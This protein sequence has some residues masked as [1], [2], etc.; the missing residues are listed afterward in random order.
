MSGSARTSRNFGRRAIAAA[1]FIWLG[2]F[3]ALPFLIVLK[4]SFSVQTDGRPP[5]EPVFD[6]SQGIAALWQSAQRLSGESYLALI[7]DRLYVDAFV[8][9]IVIAGVATLLCLS[10]A[11][12]LA[13]AMARAPR[14][15]RPFLVILAIAPFWTS[16]L[17]RIYA[18]IAILKD[19]GLLNHALISMGL[20]AE[21]L[22][23]YATTGAVLI[24]TVYS[25]LPFMVLPLYNALEKQDPALVEAA[26]D[27]GATPRRAFLSI[28]LPLSKGGVVAGSLLVFI[29]A[30]GEFVIP[31]LLGPS[32]LLMI[33][34][35][36]WDE[37]SSSRNWPG[38]SA[39]AVIMLCVLVIPIVYYQ[40]AQLRQTQART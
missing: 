26:L 22:H 11:Y 39:V 20:I 21:P 36:L 13:L 14:R 15:M 27:L 25:Y 7:Q 31:D 24:G 12:P 33:G 10:I 19:E 16:F 35:T 34:R 23:I 38:A 5:Y 37:F 30:V 8:S 1:P 28:T 6:L 18:W 2:V 40:R 9:S 29:P 17:I 32:D 4:I 3:F